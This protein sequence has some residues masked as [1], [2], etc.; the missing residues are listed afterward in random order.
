MYVRVPLDIERS[1]NNFREY[2]IGQLYSLNEVA[3]TALVRFHGHVDDEQDEIECSLDYLD[4]CFI[5]PDTAC[6][7]A[8]NGQPAR[9]LYRRSDAF[10]PGRFA[11]YF[12]QIAD[13]AGVT[14]VRESDLHVQRNRQ[15]YNP[16]A[17][18]LRYEFHQPVWKFPRDSL[19]E[20]Y[21][22]L[23]NATFGLEELVSARLMLF[24]HQA[25]VIARV[26]ADTTCRYI[27]A[28]EVGLGKTI[29]ACV[30]LKGLRRRYPHLRVLII[31]PSTLVHQWHNEVNSKFWLDLPLV[32]TDNDIVKAS[33]APGC[34]VCTEDVATD[35]AIWAEIRK[36]QWGL[37][38]VDE[39]HHVV[40]Q[41]LLYQRVH[42]LS[43]EIERVLILSATPIQR[44]KQEYLSLL[45]LVNPER[46]QRENFA[47][48]V[49]LLEIQQKLLKRIAILIDI[50]QH[51]FNAE[52]FLDELE[53]ILKLLKDDQE[54]S[55]LSQEIK[56][57][58]NHQGDGQETARAL[59]AY[60]G[61]NY[62][63][64]RRIVRNR[65]VHLDV[66]L[67][68]R[69]LDSS[70]SY[71]PDTTEAETL[72]ML[73]EYLEIYARSF[74][75]HPLTAEY[76]RI[77]MHA[78]ASS[79]RALLDI[80]ETRLAYLLTPEEPSDYD[81]PQHLLVS[82]TPRQ[83]YDRITKVL[84]QA[85]TI[86]E[87]Q[88]QF[89]EP[90]LR[91]V[92]RWH[93]Q[94]ETS[95]AEVARHGVKAAQPA[96]H[97]LLEIMR[98]IDAIITSSS[99]MK[100]ILFSSW[101][102]TI[103][104]ILPCLQKR[105]GQQAVVQFTYD[106]PYDQLQHNV[107]L[108]QGRPEC[109]ILLCDE[110]GGEGRNFQIADRVIHMDLPWTPTQ[111]E[112]RIGRI[113]R[114][115]RTGDVVSLVPFAQGWPEEDLFRLW[116]NAFH[117]FTCSMSGMEIALESVQ[118]D[119]LNAIRLHPRRGLSQLLEGMK[120]RAEKLREIVEEER[121]YEEVSIDHQLRDEFRN[122]SEK[123]RDG[124][125]LQAACL[126]WANL[127]GL[128]ID[129]SIDDTIIRFN[130]RRF[131][132]GSLKRAKF[133]QFPNMEEA[134]RRSGRQRDL[135][136]KGTFHRDIAVRRED[137]VFF[138][139]GNDPW[140]DA[141]IANAIEADTGRSC[142]IL[143]R[144]S[145]M[146]GVW[147]GFEFLYSF[148]VDPRPLFELGAD[149]TYLFRALGF[150]RTSTYRLVLSEEGRRESPGG[151]IGRLIQRKPDKARDI[152]LGKRGGEISRV[153]T[154][155]EHYPPDSW[156][157]TVERM[158][159]LAEQILSEELDDYMEEVAEEALETF[160][161]Q[162][163]GLRFASLWQNRYAGKPSITREELNMYSSISEALA[164][165]I[166]RPVRRLES[167][168]YWILQGD[169]AREQTL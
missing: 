25:E 39:A 105:Y 26:L 54:L 166:K 33:E 123:Y 88:A 137:L 3:N 77:W 130:P 117:L 87:E 20:A 126:Q 76:V 165:G 151:T 122:L 31:A 104:T 23:H 115:G 113:D 138:A 99:T 119:L 144:V 28:D 153:E 44:F 37:L 32:H 124:K 79:P 46:Y 108:F 45:A 168:C 129:T 132:L 78:S 118:S 96:S 157:L 69:K 35:K 19:I 103:E 27:L 4:R 125:L 80:A 159:L 160:D 156:Q 6:E 169:N 50:L 71:T 60:L 101:L 163:L 72:D 62:Q 53:P 43:S 81:D 167:V 97:R 21:S 92:E 106:L 24:A 38:I 112:Q 9:I 121:Y 10:L 16:K 94:T 49:H 135:V 161:R 52:D 59:L 11:E 42:H 1:D 150:L 7:L 61:E 152:H 70:H 141:I 110:S 66:A 40:K 8:H 86:P 57:A 41:P 140:L 128:S 64:E 90:L 107:D 149:P 82:T 164:E 34:I 65:R 12:V 5:L 48:F 63:I 95:L 142:A 47:D 100:V 75:E 102:A 162:V 55:A 14:S 13:T 114:I 139:P 83:E 136:I 155:K 56:K 74:I 29:E 2:R 148:T 109:R 91:M 158:F 131:N 58:A 93:E 111:V 22:E 36:Q 145:G 147:R 84:A 18:L 89:I 120:E 67:P 146:K 116:E 68:V 133:L 154:F 143:R 127:A 51:E 15:D 134:L 98:A 17:Q 30:I 73:Y 85:P